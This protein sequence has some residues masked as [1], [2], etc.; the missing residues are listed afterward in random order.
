MET[1]LKR[2]DDVK[3]HREKMPCD[4]SAASTSQGMPRIVGKH[5]KLEEARKDSLLDWLEHGLANNLNFGFLPSR[6]MRK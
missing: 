3:T 5:Q 4:R 6:T 1:H 2:E